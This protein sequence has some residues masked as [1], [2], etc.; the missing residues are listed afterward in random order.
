MKVPRTSVGSPVEDSVDSRD[1][2]DDSGDNDVT[3]GP[4][5]VVFGDIDVTWTNEV[6]KRLPLSLPN[7][8]AYAIA[9]IG[10]VF[11]DAPSPDMNSGISPSSDGSKRGDD[12]HEVALEMIPSSVS[13]VHSSSE[14]LSSNSSSDLNSH[15]DARP[16][17]GSR[18]E[19]GM[20]SEETAKPLPEEEDKVEFDAALAMKNLSKRLS[21]GASCSAPASLAYRRYRNDN[22]ESHRLSAASS[23]SEVHAEEGS[24]HTPY[25]SAHDSN[26]VESESDSSSLELRASAKEESPLGRVLD[27]SRTTRSHAQMK[28]REDQR[29]RH[30]NGLSFL[31]TTRSLD[32]KLLFGLGNARDRATD[33]SSI[34]SAPPNGPP[35]A[36]TSTTGTVQE[37]RMPRELR[38]SNTSENVAR[39]Q[40]RMSGLW[41]KFKDYIPA[42]SL[43]TSFS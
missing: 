23:F 3:P 30:I 2:S 15:F 27:R 7:D 35:D 14:R 1:E 29:F 16:S 43:N 21:T 25:Y 39:R 12:T 4:Y 33:S 5:K 34:H 40:S 19:D 20:G 37:S 36:P 11:K 32:R 26:S 24:D 17:L 8:L 22:D 13:S 38:G 9:T 10:S 18:S 28:N 6:D 41:G 31:R 42:G